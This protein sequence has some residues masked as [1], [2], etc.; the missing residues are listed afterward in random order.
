MFAVVLIEVL[1]L[2]FLALLD[3]HDLRCARLA[4]HTIGDV[5]ADVGP[6]RARLT[7]PEVASVHDVFHGINHLLPVVGGRPGNR[8]RLGS[9]HVLAE[10]RLTVHQHARWN[11]STSIGDD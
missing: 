7:V 8:H 5:L 11:E 9:P 4:G 1:F 2:I 6:R 10:L 3:A